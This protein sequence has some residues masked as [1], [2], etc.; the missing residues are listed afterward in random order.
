MDEYIRYYNKSLNKNNREARR[1]VLYENTNAIITLSIKEYII[2]LMDLFFT[3]I[4]VFS[5]R[6]LFSLPWKIIFLKDAFNIENSFPHTHFDHIFM[7]KDYYFSLNFKERIKLLIHEKLHVYQ[8]FYPIEFNKMLFSEFGLQA[9]TLISQHDDY[10]NVRM[11]PDL[12]KIIY[13]D[14][15]E[16]HLQI[17]KKNAKSLSESSNQIY[18]KTFQKTKYKELPV[19]EHPYETFAYYFS[20]LIAGGKH[21]DKKLI[22]YL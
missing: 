13:S 2:L 14:H 18:H 1:N 17:L 21:V 20:D 9:E 5:C 15:G 19:H 6:R 22:K 4:L 11:N 8:R 7:P 3:N 10:E 12:N 16:Y